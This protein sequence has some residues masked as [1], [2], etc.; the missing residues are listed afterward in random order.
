MTTR[1]DSLWPKVQF[2]MTVQP[3]RAME[4]PEKVEDKI[5]VFPLL[6]LLYKEALWGLFFNL[7]HD[8]G[9]DTSALMGSAPS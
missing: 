2:V 8:Q 3:L 9:P 7:A 4:K 5:N 6:H 1:Q